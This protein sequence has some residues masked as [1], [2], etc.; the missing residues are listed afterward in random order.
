MIYKEGMKARKDLMWKPE[1]YEQIWK[2]GMQ[3]K[4]P[5]ISNH[6]SLLS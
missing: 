3:E 2:A 5:L 4:R 1:K 6:H